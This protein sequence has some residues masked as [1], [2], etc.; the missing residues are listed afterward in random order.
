MRPLVVMM[1]QEL[2][3]LYNDIEDRL[4]QELTGER[5]HE[6]WAQLA[7]AER[8]QWVRFALALGDRR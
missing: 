2:H 5:A 7:P 6:T 8:E 3:R 4:A 1:P